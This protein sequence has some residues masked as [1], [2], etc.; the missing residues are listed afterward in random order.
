MFIAPERYDIVVI[1]GGPGGYVAAIRAAQ[2]GA[3]VCVVE[4][5]RIGGTCL[6]WGCIPTKLLAHSAETY[7]QTKSSAEL[8]IEIS[9]DI[10]INFQRV[11]QRKN[12]VVDTLGSNVI[13]LMRSHQI[14]ICEGVG[15]I[16]KPGLVHVEPS[17]TDR[18]EGAKAQDIESNAIIVATGS[19]PA[20]LPVPGVDLAGVLTSR[21]LLEIDH[22]P[23]SMVVIGGSTVGIEL[24]SIFNVMG[25]C[26]RVL[27]LLYFLKNTEEQLAKRFRGILKRQGVETS[28]GLTVTE[29]MHTNQGILR[30]AYEQGGRE[31]YAEGEVVLVSIGRWPHTVEVGLD[32]LGIAMKGRAIAV[33]EY[34]ETSV[35]GIYAV[36]DCTG[37]HMLA[38]VASYEGEVAAEN[39]LGHRRAVDYTAVPSCIF[40]TPEIA[41]V[42]LTEKQCK[43]REIEYTVSRFPFNVNGR[44]LTMGDTDG[45]I[46][47]I[48]EKG[49]DG[50]GGRILGMHIMGPHASDL[51]AEGAL[52]IK[53]GATA[54]DIAN[55]IHAH[56]TLSEVVMEVAKGQLDGAIHYW[57]R[58]AT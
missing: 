19:V 38:H 41:D 32:K 2:L 15:T 33:N 5:A 48:C 4:K 28:I 9:G 17:M 29:I 35:P 30:V 25:T 44:A 18:K 6:N 56:P 11:M 16:L 54:E 58:K 49:A 24:A 21:E 20:Q 53:M 14:H 57:K 50:K 26:V 52:A 22:L 12:E 3:H 10:R 23:K 55:T 43:E 36:G 13:K 31:S 1:G 39:A 45:Q 27:D 34:L 37:G 7:L 8:G 46:R 47:L 42:G 40:T 51:I